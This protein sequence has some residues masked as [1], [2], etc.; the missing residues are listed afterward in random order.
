MKKCD[1]RQGDVFMVNLKDGKES[2]EQGVRPCVCISTNSLNRNRGNIIIAPIT[3]KKKKKMIN[4]Y[5]IP[6]NKYDFFIYEENTVL[7]ECL[8]DISIK[9][10]ERR[11]GQLDEEDTT[12]IIN[13]TFYNFV[14]KP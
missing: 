1:L 8:R 2:E 13:R 5:I 12:N 10:L 3:S 9:R 11:I 6:N 14:E 7:L 4:H